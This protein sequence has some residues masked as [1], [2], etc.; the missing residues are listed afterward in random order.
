MPLIQV[1][2]KQVLSIPHLFRAILKHIYKPEDMSFAEEREM[3]DSFNNW[4]NAIAIEK[5]K[6]AIVRAADFKLFGILDDSVSP[7]THKYAEE[8][9]HMERMAEML[10]NNLAGLYDERKINFKE[11]DIDYRKYHR[12]PEAYVTQDFAEGQAALATHEKMF[13]EY[14]GEKLT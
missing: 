7:N 8:E 1:K 2:T 13:P 10:A 9:Y 4:K 14:Y 3:M 12:L 11:K 6:L 5:E